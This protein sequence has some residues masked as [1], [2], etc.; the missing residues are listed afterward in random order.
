MGD[1]IPLPGQC[2]ACVRNVA[3]L[4]DLRIRHQQL[5][6]HLWGMDQLP[7]EILVI[8]SDEELE[9]VPKPQA[10]P[11]PTSIHPR[12]CSASMQALPTHVLMIR[13][14]LCTGILRSVERISGE[15]RLYIGLQPHFY[16]N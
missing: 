9:E 16:F 5:E 14:R 10:V 12:V 8:S 7:R 11:R 1:L 2:G 6:Q 13:C 3:Q 4:A 15:S